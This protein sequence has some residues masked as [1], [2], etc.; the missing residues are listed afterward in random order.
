MT[1]GTYL[2]IAL[3]IAACIPV[4]EMVAKR[5]SLRHDILV[6]RRHPQASDALAESQA[7]HA[8]SSQGT[9]VPLEHTWMKFD[10]SEMPADIRATMDELHIG[11]D[12]RQYTFCGYRYDRISDAIHYAQLQ[13]LRRPAR[14]IGELD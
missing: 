8:P 3:V 11:F 14:G 12:G 7:A 1:I 5:L 9:R 13:R 4:V 2:L 10:L 6:P